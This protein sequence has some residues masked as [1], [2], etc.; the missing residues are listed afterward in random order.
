MN[1]SGFRKVTFLIVVSLAALAG[2]QVYWVVRMYSDMNRRFGEK[3]TAAMERAAYDELVTRSK[4]P[5]TI[6]TNVLQV[7]DIDSIQ[8]NRL[9]GGISKV[10]VN[11]KPDSLASARMD[12][13]VNQ[14]TQNQGF[15]KDTVNGAIV[16]QS[17]QMTMDTLTTQI[18]VQ[19]VAH[20]KRINLIDIT[21]SDNTLN[22]ADFIRYDSLLNINLAQADIL[23]PYQLS[24]LESNSG[25]VLSSSGEE[26][27][28]SLSFD[29]PI[30]SKKASLLRLS[31]QNPNRDFLKEMA[32]LIV[33]SV[34]TILLLAFAFA[35][36]LRTLFRQKSL[37][38]MRRDFTHNITHELKTPIAVAYA[39]N[40]A[41]L[42]YNADA[43]PAR[44]KKYL[45]VEQAQLQTL[46]VL[47]ERILAMSFEEKEELAL[48]RSEIELRP[49]LE[50]L[51]E[52]YEI[53][54]RKPVVFTIETEP[55]T[56]IMQ[57]DPFQF[58]IALGN[59]ID[60]ALK[61]SGER[62]EID[63]SA[64][65]TAN[66]IEIR[67]SDNG[68][69]IAPAAQDKIFEKFYRVPTGNIHTVKGFGLGLYYVRQIVENHG[70]TVSVVS[71]PGKGTVF[72]LQFPDHGPKN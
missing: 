8:I 45:K 63:I 25:A 15:R 24:I 21:S 60:N 14:I 58:N 20:G 22:S 9:H 65:Q 18:R 5:T 40:D 17:R 1:K 39:A 64:R 48:N 27:P 61:Y 54:S 38:E 3:V 30:G 28:N 41:L 50:N 33:S 31:I 55:G 36:L 37:E 34:L 6:L 43:D 59:L 19:G 72:T 67:I 46:S 7:K 32:G 44:R 53:K 29:I 71:R 23:L 11:V 62:V 57:A 4:S 13:M 16:Y 56:V 42:N 70:G 69:G 10:N 26:V 68:I 47:V 66:G 2:L 51:A 12:S 35:Y 52:T 49:V